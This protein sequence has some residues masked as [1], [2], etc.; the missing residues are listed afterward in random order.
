MKVDPISLLFDLPKTYTQYL[1][2][3]S[4][5]FQ[6]VSLIACPTPVVYMQMTALDWETIDLST[7]LNSEKKKS[8]V[9]TLLLLSLLL[10]MSEAPTTNVLRSFE[11]TC[12]RF[13]FQVNISETF[14]KRAILALPPT[15][16]T[17]S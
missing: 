10:H 9:L 1:T 4:C 14:R 6:F 8:H 17:F 2:C 13:V 3:D 11:N 7:Q 15:M 5:F 12:L 16:D